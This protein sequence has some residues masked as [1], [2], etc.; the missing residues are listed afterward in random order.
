MHILFQTGFS[1]RQALLR[2]LETVPDLA[3]ASQIKLRRVRKMLNLILI[4]MA[5]MGGCGKPS[6]SCASGHPTFKFGSPHAPAAPLQH[7]PFSCRSL[8]VPFLLKSRPWA[9]PAEVF[10]CT[11]MSRLSASICLPTDGTEQPD[12][13]ALSQKVMRQKTRV[14]SQCK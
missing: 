9:C 7:V 4:A 5:E 14:I 10:Y 6:T 3:C 2:Q 8:L 11:A 13:G 1:Q 12:S